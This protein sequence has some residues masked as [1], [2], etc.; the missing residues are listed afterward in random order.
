MTAHVSTGLSDQI[1]ELTDIGENKSE[2]VRRPLWRAIKVGGASFPESAS[3]Q[4]KQDSTT[5]SGKEDD[6]LL[7][8]IEA[9]EDEIDGSR[10][11]A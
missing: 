6:D 1:E 10:S 3:E 2:T 4:R 7:A 8:E 9:V 11:D 5:L